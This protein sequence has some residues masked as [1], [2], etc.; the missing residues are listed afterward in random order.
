MDWETGKRKKHVPD[1][2][3]TRFDLEIE[4]TDTEL[5]FDDQSIDLLEDLKAKLLFKNKN[6]SYYLSNIS[7]KQSQTAWRLSHLVFPSTYISEAGFSH[8]DAVLVQQRDKLNLEDRGDLQLTNRFTCWCIS[9]IPRINNANQCYKILLI[10]F[11][12]IQY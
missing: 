12:C 10:H 11:W 7:T 3:F 9:N 8:I 4:I 1:S 2:I 6:H 5:H